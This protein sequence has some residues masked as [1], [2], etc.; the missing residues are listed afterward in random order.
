MS[1]EQA[2]GQE[3]DQR[4]DIWSFGVLVYEMLTG[5]KLFDTPTVSDTLAAVLRAD[6]DWSALPAGL[7]SNIRTM[8]RRCLERNPKRRLRDIGDARVEPE[9]P[10]T[11]QTAPATV[12]A[13]RRSPL[14]SWILAAVMTVVAAAVTVFLVRESPPAAPLTQFDVFP[15]EKGRFYTWI[16]VSPDGRNLGFQ[17]TGADGVPRV[18]VRPIDS[19]QA[20]LLP[21]TD[22]TLTFF[23]SPDSRYVVFQSAGKLK[24]IDVLGGPPQK[25]CDGAGG[26]VGRIVERGWRDPLWRHQRADPARVG[27]GRRH[28]AGDE[29]GTRT[30]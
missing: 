22:E 16:G 26:T 8:L 11:E 30:G 29:G 18:W 9:Q 17:A 24:K 15:P 4:A 14:V 10:A 3:A 7:P 19:L 12:V 21:G 23:W 28:V 2:R 5:R 6:L 13:P 27:G 20:R 1:P 25:L